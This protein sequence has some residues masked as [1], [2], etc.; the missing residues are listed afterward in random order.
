MKLVLDPIP[1]IKGYNLV[2]KPCRVMVLGQIV[3]LEMVNKH[4]M[5]H[6]IS[7][8]TYK[9]ISKVKVCHNDDN[10]NDNDYP[11]PLPVMTMPRLFF[12]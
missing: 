10:D 12:L 11:P 3:A 4:M 1:T 6:K 8:N 7:S 2:K 5:F 9:V